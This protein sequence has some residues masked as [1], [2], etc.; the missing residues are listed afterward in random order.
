MAISKKMKEWVAKASTP[1]NALQWN[2]E[3]EKWLFTEECLQQSGCT[4][5]LT[6]HPTSVE[7]MVDKL[8]FYFEKYLG[9]K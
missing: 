3:Q 7:W 5:F 1:A 4:F 8:E 9:I 2:K 6:I